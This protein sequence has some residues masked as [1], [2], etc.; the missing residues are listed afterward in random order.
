MQPLR[1][2][3]TPAGLSLQRRCSDTDAALKAHFE[4]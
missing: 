3:H 4:Q 2:E 1:R